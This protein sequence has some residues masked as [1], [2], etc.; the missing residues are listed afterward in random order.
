MWNFTLDTIE[1]KILILKKF[2]THK[3]KGNTS[4]SNLSEK[5]NKKKRDSSIR[6]VFNA[7]GNQ[8]FEISLEHI[9]IQ[10]TENMV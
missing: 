4:S 6:E 9:N 1:K 5:Q 8:L 3:S 10:W 2:Y 7:P